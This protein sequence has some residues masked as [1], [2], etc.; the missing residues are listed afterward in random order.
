MKS[1]IRIHVFLLLQR[2]FCLS[3]LA[4][5]QNVLCVSF[6]YE[7]KQKNIHIHENILL[8]K[9]NVNFNNLTLNKLL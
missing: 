4:R 3:S 7:N 9:F 6:S 2:R 1:L 5:I 8:L